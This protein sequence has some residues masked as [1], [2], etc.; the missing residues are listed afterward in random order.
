MLN[1]E[2]IFILDPKHYIISAI[3]PDQVSTWH[4]LTLLRSFQMYQKDLFQQY[5]I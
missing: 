1:P 3:K 4:P 5:G 2:K